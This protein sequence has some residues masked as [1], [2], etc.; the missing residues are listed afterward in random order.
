MPPRNGSGDDYASDASDSHGWPDF[1]QPH[2]RAARAFS[3]STSSSDAESGY[4]SHSGSFSFDDGAPQGQQPPSDQFFTPQLGSAAFEPPMRTDS[5]A[6]FTQPMVS[7]AS[8]LARGFGSAGGSIDTNMRR[9][10]HE[11]DEQTPI[12]PSQHG[13]S[14]TASG[15]LGVRG[16]M[17]PP[18]S[19][20]RAQAGAFG[21]NAPGGTGS[22]SGIY[23]AESSGSGSSASSR[24]QPPRLLTGSKMPLPASQPQSGQSSARP[25][26]SALLDLSGWLE[27][28][29]VPS[30][31]Y[32]MG[33]SLASFGAA[34]NSM[35]SALHFLPPT[36]TSEASASATRQALMTPRDSTMRSSTDPTS[37]A[38]SSSAGAA[39][40]AEHTPAQV[41]TAQHWWTSGAPRPAA[42]L[43]GQIAQACASH[44][45]L[46]PQLLVLPDPSSPVPP[47]FHRPWLAQTRV[48]TPAS[49]AV[50]RVVIAGFHSRL[51]ASDAMA[52]EMLSTHARNVFAMA[53]VIA[54]DGDAE[55]AAATAAAWLYLVLLLTSDADANESQAEGAAERT[56]QLISEG[57]VALSTLSRALSQ[58]VARLE[59]ERRS[60]GAEFLAWGFEETLRRTLFASY[61]LLVLQRFRTP[62]PPAQQALQQSLAGVEL[63][64]DVALP[65]G[66]LEF[67]AATELEWRAAQCA[68]ISA[69]APTLRR[70]LQ[71]RS[72]AAGAGAAAKAHPDLAAYFDRHDF[73][74]NCCLI[75][76]LALDEQTPNAVAPTS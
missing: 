34:G 53:E 32:R 56:A 50:A 62:Q 3:T 25:L 26:F 69:E 72:E 48:Q 59:E 47:L 63:V 2:V 7:K 24:P 28:P 36:P 15:D 57:L 23:G 33:P 14:M 58:R 46:Y 60:A 29:V 76:A 49:L 41:M 12:G 43:Q 10:E 6:S 21:W 20:A 19:T 64:L 55:V 75:V 18:A 52:R 17:G 22:G 31:L 54:A 67:E 38:G 16:S 9:Y 11:E 45:T 73:F 61:A 68:R 5:P 35:S 65:A 40:A 4:G 13:L 1:D 8:R 74:T 71:A 66:A 37:D 51:P 70:L 44:F 39:A 42:E 30:P 27:E